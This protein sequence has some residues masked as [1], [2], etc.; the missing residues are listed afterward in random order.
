MTRKSILIRSHCFCIRLSSLEGIAM[1]H[2]MRH[3][4][5]YGRDPLLGHIKIKQR[6]VF[7]SNNLVTVDLPIYH[8]V[9]GYFN[10]I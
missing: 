6:L 10:G 9:Q 5:C 1:P 4:L 3:I 7:L 8:M 2:N